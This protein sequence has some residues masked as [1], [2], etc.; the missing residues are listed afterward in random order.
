MKFKLPK[1]TLWVNLMFVS[2]ELDIVIFSG[3]SI[4]YGKSM[5]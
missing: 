3:I 5:C 4:P 2:L 1:V